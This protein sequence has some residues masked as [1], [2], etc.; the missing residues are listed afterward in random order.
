MMPTT[1]ATTRATVAEISGED[2]AAAMAIRMEIQFS[3]S[4]FKEIS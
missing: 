4:V 1:M 2:D 3:T